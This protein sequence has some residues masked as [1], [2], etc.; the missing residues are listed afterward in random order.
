MVN[1][2]SYWKADLE[3]EAQNITRWLARYSSSKAEDPSDSFLYEIERFAFLTAFV[4]RKL[5][6]SLK[7]SQELESQNINVKAHHARV[8]AYK[9]SWDEQEISERFLFRKPT[10]IPLSLRRFCDILMHSSDFLVVSTP[11]RRL[12]ICFNSDKTRGTLYEISLKD[13]LAI[14][15]DVATDLVIHIES[16]WDEKTG[17]LRQSVRSRK[18]GH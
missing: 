9:R 12:Y 16:A 15:T 10:L 18:R 7:L 6:D 11:R 1:E 13:L 4:T 3:R 17:G 2:S 14:A 5:L 8:R